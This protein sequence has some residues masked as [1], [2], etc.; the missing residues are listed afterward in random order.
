ML[1]NVDFK[2][3]VNRTIAFARTIVIKCEEL[4]ILDNTQMKNHYGLIAGT[5]KSK[6]RYY[7]NLNG[8]YH[9]TDTMMQI[10]S[11]DNGD[12]IDFTKNNLDLHPAT[13]RAYRQGSYYYTRLVDKYPGQRDLINGIINPIPTSESIPAKN[14]EILRYNQDYVLWNEYQLIPALQSHIYNLVNTSF[15]TKYVKTDNL[16]LT[17]LIGTLYGSLVSAILQIR[18]D[19]KGTRYAHDFHIWSRLSSLGLSTVYKSVLDRKQTMWLYRNLEYV[20]KVQGRRKTFDELVEIILTHRQVPLA[21]YESVQTTEEQLTTLRPAPKLMSRPVNLQDDYGSSLRLWTVPEVITKEIP[22]ALDNLRNK[23]LDEDLTA[24]GIENGLVSRA[25]S[26]VLES[27]MMDTTDRN[28]ESLMRLLANHW[29]Y[30]AANDYYNISHDYVDLRTGSH[31]RLD[32]KE[33]YILW[34]YLI[35][36]YNHNEREEIPW[37]NY[38]GV[39][40]INPPTYLELMELGNREILTEARCKEILAVNVNYERLISPD[41]YFN[42]VKDI[43]DKRWDHTKM[44]SRIFNMLYHAQINNAINSVYE[45]GVVSLTTMKTYGEFLEFHDLSFVSYSQDELLDLA[46]SIWKRVTGWEN[47]NFISVSD[48]QRMLINLMKDLTSYTVQYI[49]STDDA[50]GNY[51]LGYQP[52]LENDSQ[53]AGGGTELVGDMDNLIIPVIKYGVPEARLEVETRPLSVVGTGIDS[54]YAESIGRGDV[55]LGLNLYQI[56]TDPEPSA[57]TIQQALTLIPVVEE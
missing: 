35:D 23:D 34:C 24:R 32:T 17:T 50:G 51:N 46:W 44:G 7:L 3:Y 39:R 56:D 38:F 42:K 26:K 15:G 33:S 25:P 41:G 53:T 9:S 13:K 40:K 36:R 12:E 6:W 14:Y 30:M 11:L 48:Q 4:A 57:Y 20:L 28:P 21:R 37:Y 54:F 2:A 8:D 18:E 10:Q 55:I 1:D 5:D 49:G 27:V 47:I 43:F 19:G 16:M 29:P 31:F 45:T 52:L 22:L